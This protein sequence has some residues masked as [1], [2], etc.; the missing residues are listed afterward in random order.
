MNE[1]LKK[2]LFTHFFNGFSAGVN[3]LGK[4]IMNLIFWGRVFTHEDRHDQRQSNEN[5]TAVLDS[6]SDGKSVSAVL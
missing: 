2:S 3:L 5:Y 6:C 4:V 1:A